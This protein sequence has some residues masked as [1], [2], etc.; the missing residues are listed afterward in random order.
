MS[1]NGTARGMGTARSMAIIGLAT[2]M[3]G[4]NCTA[5]DPP[6]ETDLASGTA[7]LTGAESEAAPGP[8]IPGLDPSPV[9][10]PFA[11][12]EWTD[13]VGA[14]PLAGM[15]EI[16]YRVRNNTTAEIQ[17]VVVMYYLG[18]DGRTIAVPAGSLVLRVGETGVGSVPVA[19]F[20]IKSSKTSSEVVAQVTVTKT[21]DRSRTYTSRPRYYHFDGRLELVTLYEER[22]LVARF[23]GGLLEGDGAAVTGVVRVDGSDRAL[24]SGETR[25]MAAEGAEPATGTYVQGASIVVPTAAEADASGGV[26]ASASGTAAGG[27]MAPLGGNVKICTK[28]NT[29]FTDRGLGEDFWTEASPT[30]RDAAWANFVLTTASGALITQGYLDSSGCTPYVLLE[31]GTYKL[32]QKTNVQRSDGILYRI[33]QASLKSGATH[34]GYLSSYNLTTWSIITDFTTS[35]GSGTVNLYPSNLTDWTRLAAEVGRLF[36]PADTGIPAGTHYVLF[37]INCPGYTDAVSCYF[38][39]SDAIF[40]DSSHCDEKFIFTH[41]TGH[42]AQWQSTGRFYFA[43]GQSVTQPSCRCDQVTPPEAQAHCL[44]SREYVYTS[45]LEGF[46]YFFAARAWNNWGHTDCKMGHPKRFRNDDGTIS[47]PPIPADCRSNVT[48]MENH[49]NQASSGVEWDWMNFFWTWN[50]VSTSKASMPEIYDVTTRACG[51]APCS[52][53]DYIYWTDYN[54]AALAKWGIGSAKYTHFSTTGDEKGVNH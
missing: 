16:G 8:A 10:P 21:G 12:F 38:Y 5:E 25:P 6:A 40:M 18:L 26:P 7:A 22:D 49:C 11:V 43:Y 37:G 35:G 44:Q 47:E 48:W 50:T 1:V 28:W 32:W 9:V 2:L 4:A 30:Y 36:Q 13:D 46:G 15:A 51:G 14:G 41:E 45:L 24:A 29:S 17:A 33:Y 42:Q 31:A 19:S 53:S 34:D 20:G 54:A 52:Y 27:G 3:F 23:A 39:G